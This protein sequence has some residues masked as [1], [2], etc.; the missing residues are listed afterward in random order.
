MFTAGFR[1]TKKKTVFLA[2]ILLIVFFL[3]IY[4]GYKQEFKPTVNAFVCN[5]TDDIITYLKSFDIDC[6]EFKID[7][8]LVPYEFG[9]V[10]TSY[11]SIQKE[12]GFDLSQLKGE[13][14]TRYTAQV[15]NYPNSDD[16]VFVEV[17]VY[18]KLIVGADIYSVSSNGF[19][20]ALK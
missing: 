17:L 11:N 16:D 3:S 10:Y 4:V 7:Q 20:V 18:N 8:V 2:V 12:Q 14:L 15:N 9:E 1:L 6:G 5:N 19:I 13:T